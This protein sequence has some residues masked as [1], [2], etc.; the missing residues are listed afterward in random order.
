MTRHLPVEHDLGATFGTALFA[1][2][3]RVVNDLYPHPITFSVFEKDML[4][5]IDNVE[6]T[7]PPPVLCQGRLGVLSLDAGR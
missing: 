7:A 1:I 5:L 2:G 6:L 4:Y 3:N